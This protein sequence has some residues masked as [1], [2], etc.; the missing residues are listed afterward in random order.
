MNLRTELPLKRPIHEY[1][2][3]MRDMLNNLVGFYEM[4]ERVCAGFST[5]FWLEGYVG[6]K[7]KHLFF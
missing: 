2:L 3:D 4:C 7:Q 6:E 1:N 5:K